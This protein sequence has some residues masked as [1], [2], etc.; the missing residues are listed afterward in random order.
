M[1]RLDYQKGLDLVLK[2]LPRLLEMGFRLY[3]QGV[4]DGGLQEAFLRAEEENPEGVRF[5]PAYDEAMARLA[6]AGAEAVLVPSRFEPCG[7]VQMIASRYGT[8][9]V[10]RAVGGS[11]TPWRT[12]GAG[13]F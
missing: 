3:V 11:R 12:G 5:L 1:G 8:P 6:Y 13:S 2:A 9:P 10:A 7:L 4:G